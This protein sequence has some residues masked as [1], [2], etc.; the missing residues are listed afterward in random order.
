MKNFSP[1]IRA[2]FERRSIRALGPDPLPEKDLEL[3]LRCLEAA[4]SAGNLQPWFFYVVKNPELKRQLCKLSFNQKAVE[5]AP[6][7]FVVCAVPEESAKQYGDA[8]RNLFCIQDTAA[9]VQNILLAAHDLG[10]GA[11]WIGV[12]NGQ[13]IAACLNLPAGQQPVALIP[14][15]Q[16]A[17]TPKPFERKGWLQVSKVI[18]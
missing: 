11:V 12:L 17:E 4:P 16:P 15:G 2:I 9:A 1:V 13:E 8:G 10:Y 14:V 18:P 7:V 6:V 5:Q 3:L